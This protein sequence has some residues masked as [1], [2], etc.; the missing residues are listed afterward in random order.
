MSAY[1]PAMMVRVLLYG[2]ATGEYSSRKIEARTYEDVALRYLS[3]DAH[4][5]HDTFAEFCK[6]HLEAL[7]GLFTQVLLLC[8]KA[9]LV[10]LGHVFIDGTKVKANASRHK[11]MSYARMGETEQGLKAEIEAL[12]KQFGSGWTPKA[13]SR[14]SENSRIQLATSDTAW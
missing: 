13:A 2:Y 3:A 6:R 12:L 14:S 9:G 4:A 11:A 5:D 1:A 7:A 8:E 10:K